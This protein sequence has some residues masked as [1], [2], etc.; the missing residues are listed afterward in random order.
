[1]AAAHDLSDFSDVLL[2]DADSAGM[3]EIENSIWIGKDSTVVN[4]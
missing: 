4:G 2:E 3:D 1:M